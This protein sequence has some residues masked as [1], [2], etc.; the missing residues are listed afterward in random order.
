MFVYD[1]RDLLKIYPGQAQPANK[2][3]TLQIREGEIFGL[4]GDN[5][6]G[7]TTLVRKPTVGRTVNLLRSTSGSITLLGEDVWQHGQRPKP[8]YLYALPGGAGLLCDAADPQA[9]ADPGSRAV[10][11]AA[12]HALTPDEASGIVGRTLDWRQR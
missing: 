9:P 5:G 8:L 6:A 7:K 12:L 3:I 1:V 11:P 2:D 4:L 10:F